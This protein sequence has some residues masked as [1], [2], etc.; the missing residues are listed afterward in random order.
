VLTREARRLIAR[1]VSDAATLTLG[2]DFAAALEAS[3]DALLR[4]GYAMRGLVFTR[5]GADQ[6]WRRT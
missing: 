4:T 6:E 2:N 5:I 1:H 3:T